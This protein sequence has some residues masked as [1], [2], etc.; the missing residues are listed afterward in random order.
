[1][2]KVITFSKAFPAYH[3]RKGEP[4]LFRDKVLL[5]LNEFQTGDDLSPKYHTIRSG[6]RWKVDEWFSPREWSEKPYRSK[7]DIITDDILIK[8]IYNFRIKDFRFWLN[9]YSIGSTS[10]TMKE[11]AKNDGL[12]LNDLIEWFRYPNDF[13]GQI[14]CWRDIKYL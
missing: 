3:P 6:H 1:M 8:R 9:G 13:D 7:Q 2:S 10:P 12:E 5:S 11:I 4:T 14:I